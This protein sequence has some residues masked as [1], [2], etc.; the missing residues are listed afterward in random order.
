M[1]EMVG[2]GEREEREAPKKSSTAS[3]AREGDCA[4][5]VGEGSWASTSMFVEVVAGRPKM[6]KTA[7]R[8]LEGAAEEDIAD[9]L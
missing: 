6:P 3:Y 5:T 9:G 8:A 7:R 2:D 4:A 1:V